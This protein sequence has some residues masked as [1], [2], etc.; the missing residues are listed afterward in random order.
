MGGGGKFG[1]HQLLR[2]LQVVGERECPGVVSHPHVVPLV[3]KIAPLGK[4]K[5]QSPWKSF[6]VSMYEGWWRNL[7]H[8]YRLCQ[9]LQR[10]SVVLLYHV[11]EPV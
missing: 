9:T 1:N 10:S 8:I 6:Q 7:S 11:D 4:T 2:Q 5:D 3:Q